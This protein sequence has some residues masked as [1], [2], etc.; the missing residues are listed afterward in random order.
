ME[1]AI[2]SRDSQRG[3]EPRHL[4]SL[5][6]VM[7]SFA[8]FSSVLWSFFLN[9]TI[10][11]KQVSLIKVCK[12]KFLVRFLKFAQSSRFVTKATRRKLSRNKP[13]FQYYSKL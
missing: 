9:R 11:R 12:C 8:L 4:A 1:Y 2:L 3:P 7:H 13:V 5:S 10:Q 6:R